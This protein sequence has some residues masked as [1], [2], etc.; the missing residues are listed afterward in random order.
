[1]SFERDITGVMESITLNEGMARAIELY[2]N[3]KKMTMSQ[4]KRLASNDPTPQKKYI[5]WMAKMWV[6]GHK[7]VRRYESLEEF[8]ELCNKNKI[9]NKDIN[10]YKSPE[11][12]DDAIRTAN[13]TMK[14]EVRSR[15]HID[16]DVLSKIRPEDIVF[17][18]DKVI[19]VSPKDFE[20]SCLY[21]RRAAKAAKAEGEEADDD[22]GAE[23]YWC[24]SSSA[25]Y[26]N[27]Y[28]SSGNN[29]YYMLPKKA[30]VVPVAK[31]D[32]SR[33]TR[34]DRFAKV[35]VRIGARSKEYPKGR[36]G[37]IRDQYNTQVTRREFDKLM[38][39]WGIPETSKNLGP[40]E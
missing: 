38:S 4:I 14:E 27:D 40:D 39:A 6:S 25:S 7:N 33:E 12:V 36:L 13:L 23:S 3:T 37:E 2:V 10:A 24:V 29:L 5:E 11:E 19:V 35:A 31:E 16:T 9:Q 8:E 15:I 34:F 22:E 17:E 30:E 1:M 20:T 21:G 32:K 28:F 18:N 26:W